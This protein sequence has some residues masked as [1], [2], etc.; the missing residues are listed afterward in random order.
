MRY[1]YWRAKSF[2]N[3]LFMSNGRLL[4]LVKTELDDFDTKFSDC[5][6]INDVLDLLHQNM[7]T[8]KL[9]PDTYKY[10]IDLV[11]AAGLKALAKSIKDLVNKEGQ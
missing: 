2:F 9:L 5:Y 4:R 10:G 6:K 11:I 8:L 7:R 3:D 1:L